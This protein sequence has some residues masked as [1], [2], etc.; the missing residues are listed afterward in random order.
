MPDGPYLTNFQTPVTVAA[1]GVLTNDFGGTNLVADLVQ[2]E[3]GTVDLDPSG[4]FV[5]TPGHRPLRPGE[6]LVSGIRRH[7]LQRSVHRVVHG[8]LQAER[9]S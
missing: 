5:F 7:L 6:F 4:S 2:T 3:N 9:G 8:E 1:P